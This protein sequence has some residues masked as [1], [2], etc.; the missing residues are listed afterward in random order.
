MN[1]DTL[2]NLPR[3]AD[4]LAHATE[5]GIHSA[6]S[7]PGH[8]LDG[9]AAAAHDLRAQAA[10]LLARATEQ[11]G[12]LA[13]R[14]VDSVRDTSLRL[15]DRA[16]RASDSTLDYIRAEPLKATLIAAATGAALLAVV[17]L[18]SRSRD[19]S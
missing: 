14:G 6:G 9:L 2:S 4:S 7:L 19:R 1:T 13:Q 16:H 15:R 8:A 17:A 10:P 3:H 18:L 12:A 5:R 11:A